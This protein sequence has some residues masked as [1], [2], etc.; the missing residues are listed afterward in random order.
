MV[1]IRTIRLFEWIHYLR[2]Y[3]D[4]NMQ[5]KKSKS[6]LPKHKK[7]LLLTADFCWVESNVAASKICGRQPL[8]ALKCMVCSGRPYHFKCFK[9]C[10]PQILLGPFLNTLPQIYMP[11]K[12]SWNWMIIL[13]PSMSDNFLFKFS[14]SKNKWRKIRQLEI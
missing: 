6:V 12:I 8:K 11:L 1:L 7:N 10:L 9:G 14:R 13:W 3:T 2:N 4:L 5:L